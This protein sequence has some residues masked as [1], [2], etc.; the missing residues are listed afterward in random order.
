MTKQASS[1]VVAVAMSPAFRAEI[2]RALASGDASKLS[3]QL[4]EIEVAADLAEDRAKREHVEY[5]GYGN[6]ETWHTLL[7]I[8]NEHETQQEARALV[9]SIVQQAP[10]ASQV[11]DGIWTAEQATRYLL[12]DAL[13]DWIDSQ[14]PDLTGESSGRLHAAAYMR[15]GFE[16]VDWSKVAD[17]L[18]GDYRESQS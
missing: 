15:D 8:N 2:R 4:R 5:D 11:A 6:H 14:L 18:L 7:V 9:A 1:D 13:R 12:A 3:R 17:S 16:E 10:Q